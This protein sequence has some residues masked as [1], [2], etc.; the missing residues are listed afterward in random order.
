MIPLKKPETLGILNKIIKI[1]SIVKTRP[2]LKS[3]SE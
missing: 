1:P 2:K 3:A